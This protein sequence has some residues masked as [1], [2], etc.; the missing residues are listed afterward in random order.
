MLMSAVG[1]VDPRSTM[2]VQLALGHRLTLVVAAPGWGKTTLLRSLAL[3]APAVEAVRPPTGWTP[4]GLARE[5]LTALVPADELD[6]QLPARIAPDTADQQAHSS[7]LAAAVC[8]AAA[9][10]VAADTLVL[11]DDAD[12]DDGDPLRDF[13]EAMVMQLPPRLHLVLASRRQP[14]LRIARLKAAGQVARFG[15]QDL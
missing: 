8:D 3:A 10:A 4:F 12:V 14:A 6:D 13:L 2:R 15:E 1:A 7:A 9:Q 5:L 11:L